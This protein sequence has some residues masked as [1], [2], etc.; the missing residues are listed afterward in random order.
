MKNL[1]G[2]LVVLGLVSTTASVSG[3]IIYVDAVPNEGTGGGNTT[4]NGAAVTFNDLDAMTN[5]SGNTTKAAGSPGVAQTDGKWHYR[6]PSSTTNATFP[7]NNGSYWETD[8]S[9]VASSENAPPLITTISVPAPGTYNL[10]VMYI[11]STGNLTGYGDIMVGVNNSDSSTHKYFNHQNA[12][13]AAPFDTP[14]VS[15]LTTATAT[16]FDNVNSSP[17]P[18]R[19]RWASSGSFHMYLANL[20]QFDLTDTTV[21]FSFYITCPNVPPATGTASQRTIYEGV[22]YELVPEPSALLLTSCGLIL[23]VAVL[24]RRRTARR[25]S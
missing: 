16:E 18:V 5:P 13:S 24:G 19:T 21:S 23:S 17:S 25:V 12:S 9:T 6:T 10:Y 20:G 4:V 7:P 1:F 8:G 15:T 14:G 22:A 3:A 2:F 11:M